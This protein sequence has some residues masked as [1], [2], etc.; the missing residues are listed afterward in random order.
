M[1]TIPEDKKYNHMIGKQILCKTLGEY[2]IVGKTYID[3]IFILTFT[4]NGT[5][6]PHAFDKEQ[7]CVRL[8][9]VGNKWEINSIHGSIHGDGM[10]WDGA[11]LDRENNKC[12]LYVANESHA[13]YGRDKTYKRVFGFG[14][15]VCSKD[16]KW[17][18]TEFVIFG[19]N[20]INIYN[21]MNQLIAPNVSYFGYAGNIGNEDDD[22]EW[23][24]GST[25]IPFHFTTCDMHQNGI[26]I[27][28][29]D[30]SIY[31]GNDKTVPTSIRYIIRTICGIVWL[32]FFGFITYNSIIKTNMSSIYKKFGLFGLYLLITVILFITGTYIGWEI[33][34][35]SPVNDYKTWDWPI[36]IQVKNI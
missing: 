10:W 32:L 22:Q 21:D 24:G 29:S 7:A 28:F 33:F 12:I 8:V 6:E 1:I 3:L 17:S 4:W 16:I 5:R 19:K 13:L 15:D 31:S 36:Q 35:L 23:P 14:N 27:L 18:P 2:S 30:T 34:I 9:K 20:S 11:R 26:D 25:F